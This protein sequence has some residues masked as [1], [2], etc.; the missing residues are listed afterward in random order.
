MNLLTEMLMKK[1]CMKRC[2]WKLIGFE[3]VRNN[4]LDKNR[5]SSW[6]ALQDP[7]TVLVALV[8]IPTGTDSSRCSARSMVKRTIA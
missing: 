3:L 5:S 1:I 2:A 6:S 7:I 4:E 8:F